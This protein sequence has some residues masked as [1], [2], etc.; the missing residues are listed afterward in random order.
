MIA[1]GL[2]RGE[3]ITQTPT[4]HAI[5]AVTYLGIFSSLIGFSAF[6]YLIQNT[7]P[8]LAMSYSYVN[9]VVASSQ[10][11]TSGCLAH[12]DLGIVEIRI[13]GYECHS[14]GVRQ[15]SYKRSQQKNR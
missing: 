2:C 10:S 12:K 8:A 13:A 9:P 4:M 5:L 1:I 3:W 14:A 6:T 11:W 7:R 15:T